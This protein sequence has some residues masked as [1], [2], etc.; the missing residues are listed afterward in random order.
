[1]PDL[2]LKYKLFVFAIDIKKDNRIETP[3]CA[4]LV[5]AKQIIP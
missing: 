3:F 1:M 2:G 4:F 5:I